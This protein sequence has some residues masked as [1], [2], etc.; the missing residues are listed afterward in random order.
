MKIIKTAITNDAAILPVDT[1]SYE[2]GSWLIL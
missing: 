1:I 2:V